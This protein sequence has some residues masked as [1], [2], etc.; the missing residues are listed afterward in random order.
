MDI[1]RSDY[2]TITRNSHYY[3]IGHLS[4]VVKPGAVPVSYTHLD[5]YKRQAE[6]SGGTASVSCEEGGDDVK[7][8]RPLHQMCIRDR[9][10]NDKVCL[11]RLYNYED[12]SR[13]RWYSRIPVPH[14]RKCLGST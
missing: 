6:D 10:H 11:A 7:S 8:A 3:I 9:C 1:D 2:K 13:K 5:V 12:R 14:N 4:S